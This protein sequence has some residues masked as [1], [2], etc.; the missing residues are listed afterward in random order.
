[1]GGGKGIKVAWV[2]VVKKKKE[3]RK[4]A[5]AVRGKAPRY[6]WMTG[7]KNRQQHLKEVSIN[8]EQ[9][10]EIKEDKTQP[11]LTAQRQKTPRKC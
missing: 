5:A 6:F 3:E 10:G 8:A 2:F 9:V 4:R 1:M 7:T 11:S